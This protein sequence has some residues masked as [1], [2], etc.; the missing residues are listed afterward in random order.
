M[1]KL[2][3]IF[4]IAGLAA[5]S[6]CK[7]TLDEQPQSAV[8]QSDYWTTEADAINAVNNCYRRLGDVDNRIFISCATDD[9]YSW[10]DWPSDVRLVGNGSASISTGMFNNFWSNLYKMI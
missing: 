10:S 2:A 9:S 6:A 4:T 5:V 3:I 1:K 7:K 8:S